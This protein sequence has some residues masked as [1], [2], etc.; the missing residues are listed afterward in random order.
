MKAN[1]YFTHLPM[2]HSFLK[3]SPFAVNQVFLVLGKNQSVPT[4]LLNFRFLDLVAQQLIGSGNIIIL[5]IF[6]CDN[7]EVT[8]CKLITERFL[9]LA[10]VLLQKLTELKT[11]FP[12]TKART[13]T[14]SVLKKLA[15]SRVPP[16][17]KRQL[18]CASCVNELEA[19][20][21]AEENR[22]RPPTFEQN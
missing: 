9:T 5:C 13:N 16:L 10:A 12:H 19:Q 3:V 8:I 2:A 15:P 14:N 11:E 21:I 4:G 6:Y 7:F 20:E 1:S 17:P 18:R 22:L